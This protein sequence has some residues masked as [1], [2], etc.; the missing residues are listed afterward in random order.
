[1]SDNTYN[2]W[3]N[4]ATWNVTLWLD[5]EQGSYGDMMSYAETAKSTQQLAELIENY[6]DQLRY[7]IYGDQAHEANL[8]TDVLN[9]ALANVNWRE[10]AESYRDEYAEEQKY[11]K[12]QAK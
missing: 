11:L 9:N 2:G 10:I 12:E 3:T 6:I 5:N 4:Y 1:M 8:F 7:T